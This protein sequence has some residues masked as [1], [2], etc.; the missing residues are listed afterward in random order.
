MITGNSNWTTA[1]NAQQKK[2]L[3]YLEIVGFAPL[4]ASF[5]ASVEGIT[6]PGGKTFYP[7]L[8]IPQGV[9][10]TVNELDGHANISAFQVT[11]ID[12]GGQLKTLA[13]NVAVIGSVAKLWMGFSGNAFGDFVTLHQGRVSE[14]GRTA[15]GLMSITIGDFNLDLVDQIWINGGPVATGLV[16]VNG[17]AVTWKSGTQ[18]SPSLAG[19]SITIAGVVN[20]IASVSDLQDLVLQNSMS[21]VNNATYACQGVEGV[22]NVNGNAVTLVGGTQFDSSGKWN[23]APIVIGGRTLQVSSVQSNGALTLTSDIGVLNGAQYYSTGTTAVGN[24]NLNFPP[25]NP[26]VRDNGQ[27]IASDNPRFL[28]GNPMEI[29][30]AALQNELGLGQSAPPMLVVNNQGGSGTGQAGYAINPSWQFYTPGNDGTLINP[31]PY[32]DVPGIIAL[33]DGMFSGDRM[34]FKLT[35][36]QTG[37]S[38]IEDQILKPLGLYWIT[39]STGQLSLKSMKPPSSTSPVALTGRNIIDIPEI[40]RWPVIN[41]VNASCLTSPDSGTRVPFCFGNQ[42]S[43]DEY[44]APAVQTEESDGLVPAFGAGMRLFLISARVFS[45]HGFSTPEYTIKLMFK[46]L[47]LELGDFVS[48]THPLLLDLVAGTIGVTN[49][50][51]EIVD[52]QPDYANK[53]MTIK[54]IDTRFI[55]FSKGYEIAAAADSIP[56]YGSASSGQKAQ[57][58]FISQNNGQYSD[59]SAAH[60]IY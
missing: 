36:G 47:V 9:G 21:I 59:A 3:F 27:P 1:L 25:F 14:I 13:A 39:K 2:A 60:A 44:L 45:R 41:T 26:M 32:V 54:V 24:Q 23:G 49:V 43:L 15:G 11:C 42:E 10:Q 46:E 22:V 8:Q 12:P 48:L 31:N 19:A 20:V 58:M 55:K 28:S 6:A 57:Y 17:T 34:E 51:C 52:R 30:L 38:W 7:Y 56:V 35:S 33:R 16:N 5:V 50:L 29:L 40:S 18:F 53:T 4:L 37:K